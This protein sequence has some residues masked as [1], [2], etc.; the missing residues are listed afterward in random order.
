[1]LSRPELRAQR[2]GLLDELIV[3]GYLEGQQYAVEGLLT[4]GELR[5]WVSGTDSP[6]A[7]C[8]KYMGDASVTA[9]GGP[10]LIPCIFGAC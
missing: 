4:G 10:A 2:T 6:G 8:A 3:E 7:I 5:V 1:M 9:T